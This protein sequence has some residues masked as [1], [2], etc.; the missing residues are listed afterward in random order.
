MHIK[1][2]IRVNTL[3]QQ[4]TPQ[5]SG[6]NTILAPIYKTTAHVTREVKFAVNYSKAGS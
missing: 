2:L 3:I 5:V 4:H 6:G 1:I